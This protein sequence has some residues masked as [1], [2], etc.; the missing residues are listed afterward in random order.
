MNRSVVVSLA[1][2]TNLFNFVNRVISICAA[3]FPVRVSETLGRLVNG[4]P[5][6]NTV[7]GRRR[8][9]ARD[10]EVRRQILS[11]ACPSLKCRNLWT[12]PRANM[13]FLFF[14]KASA[15]FPSRSFLL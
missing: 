14:T 9:F 13:I 5:N 3:D 1:V 12:E 11:Y 7:G 8:V 6:S 2:E 10:A 15:G 4:I